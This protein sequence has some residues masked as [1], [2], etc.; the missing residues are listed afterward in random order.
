MRVRVQL[1]PTR[2]VRPAAIRESAQTQNRNSP[3]RLGEEV[4]ERGTT[5]S[6]KNRRGAGPDFQHLLK[7]II[8]IP[9]VSYFAHL[10]VFNEQTPPPHI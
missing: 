2:P 9:S 1:P 4:R 6:V 8:L 3:L 7:T 5:S 10:H